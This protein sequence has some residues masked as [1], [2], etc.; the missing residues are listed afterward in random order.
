MALSKSASI[1]W[2]VSIAVLVAVIFVVISNLHKSTDAGPI[3]IGVS[4]ILSGDFAAAGVNMVNAAK[5]ATADINA[6]GGIHGR[7]V[8][9]LIQDA[10]W[11]SKTG[12]A[13]AQKLINVDGV[14]YIIGGTSSNGTIASAPLANSQHVIYMTPV[15]G[16]ANVDDAGEYI[17]RTAN[18]DLLAGHDLAQAVAKFGYKRVA[19]ITEVTEYTL[20]I[21]KTF[22]STLPSLGSTAVDSEEFQPGT[23]D[24]RTIATKVQSSKPDA[25]LVLS[26]TGVGGAYFVKQAKEIG[27][28]A[29]FFS[30][31]TFVTNDNAKKIVGS[32]DGMYFA[33]AAYD[34]TSSS[35][36]AFFERYSKTY[37]T[38][39]L[40]PF[41]A[42]S[43]YDSMMMLADGLRA[44]GDN[45][46]KVHDWLLGN[47]K[48]WN[49]LMGTYSLDAKGN[50]DLG[51]VIKV[52]KNGNPIPVSI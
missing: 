30:D 4:T 33:D 36:V 12:L 28:K 27:I 42:A 2:I 7:Q 16:G 14:K 34:S 39:S 10:G 26:Q 46:A 5:L 17:F 3:K 32:F 44:A 13:A 50:S 37:G 40:I 18:S 11:D 31:F 43:T 19:I 15:T 41:H 6:S 45:S 23:T 51:F 49:G 52:M 8:E 22:E 9:L 25:I 20:D 24:F 35:S 29:P 21:K 47:I 38:A 48:N 1:K